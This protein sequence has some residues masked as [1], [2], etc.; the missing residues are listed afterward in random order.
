[1]GIMFK[2][3]IGVGEV[4]W[5]VG[6]SVY[7]D[8][9]YTDLGQEKEGVTLEEMLEAGAL[10]WTYEKRQLWLNDQGVVVKVPNRFGLVRQD[11]QQ[12][13]GLS[14]DRYDP[15]QPRENLLFLEQVIAGLAAFHM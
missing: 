11:T 1:M 12:V 4:P 10:D 6:H 15:P 9:G 14:S 3:A 2:R 13:L 8:Q 5:W 7:G